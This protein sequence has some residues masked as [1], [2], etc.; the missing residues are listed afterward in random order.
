VLADDEL[1]TMAT[2]IAQGRA[3]YG[4]IRKSIHYLL[5]TNLSEIAVTGLGVTL[6]A[7]RLVTPMQ[8]LWINLVSDVVPALALALEP[9]EPDILD[10][11]P[12]DPASPILGRD[13]FL[14]F[15]REGAVI[16]AGSL[17]SW[18]FGRWRYGTVSAPPQTLAFSTLTFAQLLHALACR[19]EH[20]GLLAPGRLPRNPWMD[21]AVP[22][23]L[24]IQAS[25]HAVPP[26]RRF[27]GM[28]PLGLIDLAV[29]AGASLAPF[30]VNETLKEVGRRRQ[31]AGRL[32]G[33]SSP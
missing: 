3:I 24:A 12:R 18:A 27:L 16:S 15:A 20:R 29:V 7:D 6:G 5:A 33:G 23:S 8:L 9:L 22:T 28:A 10:R 14:R 21:L 26:L 11:P 4:N 2:A 1:A 25:T 17:A 13:D 30:L 19:S 32:A 31:G